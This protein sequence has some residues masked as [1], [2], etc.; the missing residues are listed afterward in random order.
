[1]YIYTM[2]IEYQAAVPVHSAALL[3]DNPAK[4]TCV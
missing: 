3:E 1:V 2:T 4:A